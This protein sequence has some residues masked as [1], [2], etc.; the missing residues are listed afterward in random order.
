MAQ[1]NG[2]ARDEAS[3]SDLTAGTGEIDLEAKLVTY[4]NAPGYRDMAFTF[5][6]PPD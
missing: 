5:D 4:G 3:L 2:G 6:P 1:T